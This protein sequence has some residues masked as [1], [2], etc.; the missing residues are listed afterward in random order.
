MVVGDDVGRL[1]FPVLVRLAGPIAEPPG[2]VS[3]GK[4]VWTGNVLTIG[5]CRR[6]AG[7]HHLLPNHRLDVFYLH[8][9]GL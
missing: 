8:Q 7:S 5:T 4:E 6:G 9:P 1:K 2:V 3:C